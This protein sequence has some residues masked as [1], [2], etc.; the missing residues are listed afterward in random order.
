[1]EPEEPRAEDRLQ[2][3]IDGPG[4]DNQEAKNPGVTARARDAIQRLQNDRL[5]QLHQAR[6]ERG[7]LSDGQGVRSRDERELER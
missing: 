5:A 3:F 2:T 4:A 1:M 7:T 6:E